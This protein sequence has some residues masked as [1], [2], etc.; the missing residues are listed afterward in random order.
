MKSDHNYAYGID[1]LRCLSAVLVAIFHFT[2]YNPNARWGMPFGWVGVEVFFVISGVV[3][4]NSASAASP[5]EFVIG[6]FL[7]LYPAAWIAA[8]LTKAVL[9]EIQDRNP[10]PDV[11]ALLWEVARMRSLI[12]YADQLQRM[13]TTLPGPQGAILDTL[14]S[15]LKDEPCVTEFPR[16]PPG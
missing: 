14:R 10:D 7:R 16:L 1:A 6:R 15:K 5:K 8:P 12:L 4:A 9:Q 11:R 13:L 3:I 2:Y